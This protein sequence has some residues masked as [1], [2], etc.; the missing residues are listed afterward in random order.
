MFHNLRLLANKFRF[1]WRCFSRKLRVGLIRWQIGNTFHSMSR[2]PKHIKRG[3]NMFPL[4]E[5][6]SSIHH[7]AQAQSMTTT[8]VALDRAISQYLLWL[9]IKRVFWDFPL[10]PLMHWMGRK[11]ELTWG[12]AWAR[13]LDL[14]QLHEFRILAVWLNHFWEDEFQVVPTMTK[15]SNNQLRSLIKR[16]NK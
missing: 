9:S 10:L 14:H 5:Y 16:L 12:L 13:Q 1:C 6:K 15:K 8:H 4:S 2:R 11:R 3:N 7:R